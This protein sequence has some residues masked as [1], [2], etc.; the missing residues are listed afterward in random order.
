MVTAGFRRAAFTP[1]RGE[2]F[3]LAGFFLLGF[4]LSVPLLDRV[5]LR[6]DFLDAAFFSANFFFVFFLLEPVFRLR[7]FFLAGMNPLPI[8]AGREP[9]GNDYYRIR[10][11]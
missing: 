8:L 7:T 4:F 10:G 3:F 2:C 5:F 9:L 6:V 1:V 11:G